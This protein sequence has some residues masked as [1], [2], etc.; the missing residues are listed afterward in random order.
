MRLFYKSPLN[1]PELFD[2]NSEKCAI[3]FGGNSEYLSFEVNSEKGI[4]F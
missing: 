2:M 4:I 1:I 3:L